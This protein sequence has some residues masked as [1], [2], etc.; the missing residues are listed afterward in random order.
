VLRT[1]AG[2]LVAAFL[3]AT[4]VMAQSPDT[5]TVVVIATDPSG[6]VVRDARVSILNA[7]T[8]ARREVRSGTDGG[9][10][11]AGLPIGGVY[12][13][14]VEKGGFAE[15]HAEDLV[16]RAGE[17]A[18]VR[19]R[20]T[21]GAETADV[22]VYGTV[23]G[24]RAQPQLGMRLDAAQIDETPI[25]GRKVTALP[26]LNSAFRSGKGTGDLFINQV[27]A[28]SGAGGRREVAF[29][30]DGAGADEPWGRQTM[31]AIVPAAAVQEMTVLSNA[32]SAEFGW[33]ASPAVNVVTKS[34][35]NAL[36]GEVQYL[37]RPGSWQE[38]TASIGDTTVTPADVPDV[39]H[40][41]SAALGGPLVHDQTFWFAA[42][43]FS[44][45]D[46]TAYF[47]RAVPPALLNGLTSY[48]GNYKQGLLDA[49]VD[50][51]FNERH[52][53]MARANLDRFTD[54]NPQ[55][56]VSGTT[57]PS[58]GRSFRRHTSSVQVN[59]S[60]VL[61]GNL[62]NEARIEYQ[63]GDPITDFD[64][65]TPS[66]QFARAG[67]ATEGESRYSHVFSKQ[68]QLS[69]AMSWTR[70]AHDLR[71]GGSLARHTS[72]GDGTEFGGAFVLG[73]FTI[74]PA[75]RAPIDQLRIADA[76]RY[77]QTFDFGVSEYALRQW[78]YTLFA[79]DTFRVRP[80]LTVDLG[81]RYDRQTFSDGKKN[82]APRIGFGWHP[83]GD[84]ETAIRGGYGV[85][86]TMLRANTEANFTLNGPEG[87]FTY[88]V[89]PGQL[90]F[91]SS[92]TAVPIQFPSGAVLPARNVTIRPGRRDYYSRFF[93]VDALR[94]YPDALVNPKSQVASIGIER[95]LGR[96]LFISA[97]YVTQ[98][99]TGLDRAVDLNAPSLFVRTAPG[100]VRPA[101]A[102]DATRPIA[103]VANGFRQ[104]NAIENVGVA[105]YDGLQTMVRWQT[106]RAFAS[107]S[108]TLSKATNTTEPN[109]NG[110]NPN[111]FNQIG[112]EER[113]P[114]IL[115]QRHRAVISAM[116]RLPYHVTVGAVNQLASARPF[117]AMTG[118]DNNGDGAMNDRPVVNGQVTGRAS[119]RGTPMYD[120]QVFAEVR[121]P[122]GPRSLAVRLE[123]FNVFNHANILGRT[124]VYGNGADPA[125]NFGTPAGGLANID[126]ARQFQLLA[127]FAF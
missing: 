73:Q 14:T 7:Q 40:Q 24:V 3:C 37:E 49:R 99:W 111:D 27:Y 60:A 15:G 115:D 58:A 107:V 66:T 29:A 53:L 17:T 61:S 16:L 34:G 96:G 50:H 116:Y 90:G 44:R 123:G 30:V 70:G 26:L 110:P 19:V 63:H 47:S 35:T 114:S 105:D 84:A 12:T 21:L 11:I 42:G 25:L 55:D 92:L 80:D 54:D 62:L 68:L 118:V 82:L 67:V 93:D 100:Q 69:D 77:T 98:H 38:R 126:P 112:E 109:G 125:P 87:Q 108:Y 124:G 79:Q 121:I 52:T 2:V 20:L 113:G 72:G 10:V 127:R 91:P 86:Y 46:R 74:N 18:T 95:H 13:V 5:A 65:R 76:T 83:R 36:R 48:T 106:G 94:S 88:S 64:P 56:V 32:F 31:F 71:L 119:F 45:Q 41:F 59:E 28:V 51:K 81:L 78:I 9:A 85:Y 22:T 23:E 4:P 122:F 75:A 117:N 101:P 8:G 57:L 33:T 43:E 104:I 97:D 39:L 89:A 102:A 120:T 103:P 1:V 6:A